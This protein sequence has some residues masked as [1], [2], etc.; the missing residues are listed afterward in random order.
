M[1]KITTRSRRTKR[2]SEI[3]EARARQAAGEAF[4]NIASVC[5][6]IKRSL[7]RRG[8]ILTR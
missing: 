1:L 6:K 5:C 7:H 3:V 8:A 2:D 4:V